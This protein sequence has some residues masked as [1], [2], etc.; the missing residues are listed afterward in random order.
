MTNEDTQATVID[1]EAV[2]AR[3]KELSIEDSTLASVQ[4]YIESIYGL[5]VD[6]NIAV[7]EDVKK[8]LLELTPV[9]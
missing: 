7:P 6:G 5:D 3:I 8:V 1:T 4:A 2:V 9:E